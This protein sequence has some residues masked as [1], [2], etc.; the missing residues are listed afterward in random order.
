MARPLVGPTAAATYVDRPN[1][2]HHRFWA[3][4]RPDGSIGG[5]QGIDLAFTSTASLA[6]AAAEGFA[7]R[8]TQGV[9]DTLAEHLGS[10]NDPAAVSGNT[11]RLFEAAKGAPVVA[12]SAADLSPLGLPADVAARA[13]ADVAAGKVVVVAKLDTGAAAWWRVDP[14]TGQTVGVTQDGYNGDTTE[15]SEATQKRMS[16]AQYIKD[17]M[18]DKAFNELD[19]KEYLRITRDKT[20]YMDEWT[21]VQ[22]L[23]G[24]VAKKAMSAAEQIF[25][26]RIGGIAG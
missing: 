2:I 16:R 14:V 23:Q 21:F 3:L 13:A 6:P 20:L 17:K 12:R 22:R 26:G 24:R 11:M 19:A 10:A 18:G 4:E 5:G 9:A 7:A 8:L 1:V 25:A 15:Y